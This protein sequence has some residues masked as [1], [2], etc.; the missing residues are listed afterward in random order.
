MSETPKKTPKKPAASAEAAFQTLAAAI[1]QEWTTPALVDEDPLPNVLRDP[2]VCL[3]RG[4]HL[5]IAGLHFQFAGQHADAGADDEEYRR[6]ARNGSAIPQAVMDRMH[7]ER[8]AAEHQLPL[9]L[10]VKE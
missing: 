3:D 9:G 2:A 8:H 1:E 7:A 5:L 4:R 6:A 10:D